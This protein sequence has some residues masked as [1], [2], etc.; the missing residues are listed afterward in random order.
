MKSLRTGLTL[1][2][3]T[4]LGVVG[5]VC[6]GVG[7]L[8]AQRETQGQVDYQMQQVAR[9]ISSQSWA[10]DSGARQVDDPLLLPS[11]YV[12]HDEDDDLIVTVR[13]E[14]G[15]LLYASPP[16]RRL[17]QGV[18]P[19]LDDLGFQ[20]LKIG[21][22]S[23]RVFVARSRGLRIQVAQSMDV[24]HEAEGGIALATLLPIGLL[25]PVL[26]IVL[27]LAIRRQLKPLNLAATAVASRPPLSLDLLPADAVPAEVRPLMDEINRLLRRLSTAVERE[28]RFVTDAAHALRTPLTALQLQAEI[29]DGGNSPDERAIRLQELKAGIRRVIRLS[30]QLLSLARSQSETGPITVTTELDSTLQEIAALYGATARAK[31]INIQVATAAAARVYGNARRLTLIFGNLLDNSLRVTPRGG[32][33]QIKSSSADGVARVE[34]W[35]EGCGLPPEELERVFER[36]Y[37]ASGNEGSGSGLGLATVEA[38]VRQLSGRVIL[39]NRVDGMGLVATVI[40]PLAPA[41]P[42]VPG[43]SVDD[44][45]PARAIGIR[46]LLIPPAKVAPFGGG[47]GADV[48]KSAAGDFANRTSGP[49]RG[50]AMQETPAQSVCGVS[51][52]PLT[53]SVR[54]PPRRCTGVRLRG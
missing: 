41:E 49:G 45:Y 54:Y 44:E 16:N 12:L 34:V 18:L 2:L 24:I 10:S 52:Y 22:E 28:Q 14:A 36:F 1:W 9:I 50:R 31:E 32:H 37:Q 42:M 27:G 40:L 33:I 19:S 6:A 8:Q 7:I 38:L 15:K 26:A 46:G 39:E 3:W 30:E 47:N 4:T 17:P 43:L 23:F 21:D 5:A 20:T 29:L 53:R 13:N 48:C 25:L 51:F 11:I 35:D